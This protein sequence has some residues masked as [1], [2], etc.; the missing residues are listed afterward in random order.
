[1][2][3]ASTKPYLVSYYRDG[4]IHKIRRTP[5]PKLH[6]LEDGDTTT[7][8]RKKND[9]W[10]EGDKVTIKGYNSRHPN[11]LQI[12]KNGETS[13]LDFMDLDF[14]GKDQTDLKKIAQRSKQKSEKAAYQYLLWP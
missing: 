9:D 14:E 11:T 5:P 2:S 13:F 3:V 4:Q 7:I 12:E 1:M 10:D 6:P 8:T